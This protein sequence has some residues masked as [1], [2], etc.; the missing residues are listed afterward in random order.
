C[1]A[2]GACLLLVLTLEGVI[3][4]GSFALDEIAAVDVDDNPGEGGGRWGTPV[5]CPCP[6]GWRVSGSTPPSPACSGCRALARRRSSSTVEPWS[7]VSPRAS[8]IGSRRV[9]GSK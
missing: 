4:V 3:R 1:V 6:T 5:A 7:T 8:P 2:A 9:F